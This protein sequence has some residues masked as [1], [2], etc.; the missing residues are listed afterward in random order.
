MP[1]EQE[2]L[3]KYDELCR[4]VYTNPGMPAGTQEVVLALGWLLYRHPGRPLDG[5]PLWKQLKT[6]LRRNEIGRPRIWDL[7]AA[8]APRYQPPRGV[9]V[10]S[11]TC[12]GPRVRPYR[13]RDGYTDPDHRDNRVCG[14]HAT[15]RVIEQ[16]MITGWVTAHWFCRRHAERASEVKAQIETRG[17]PPP[18]IPNTGGILPCYFKADW[19]QVYTE[20]V[21]KAVHGPR[22]WER[23]YH[24]IRANDWPVP[25]Q[26]QV[27]KRPRLSV[28]RAS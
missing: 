2:D 26:Q 27:P 21:D 23:P 18:P 19:E 15:I 7:I 14:A 28:L 16:D 20:A 12:E 1:R 6:M 13:R 24:G 5:A 25:G 9:D 10:H 3:A 17:E 4:E 11:W 8:D 22:R